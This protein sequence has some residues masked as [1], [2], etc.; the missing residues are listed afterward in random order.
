[1]LGRTANLSPLINQDLGVVVEDSGAVEVTWATHTTLAGSVVTLP[2]V[3]HPSPI[4]DAHQTLMLKAG[5][6]DGTH[7]ERRIHMQ[8]EE[9]LLLGMQIRELL[10]LM[11]MVV[12][13]RHTMLVQGHRI[14]ITVGVVLLLGEAR[15]PEGM[16]LLL[17]AP[18]GVVL[19]PERQ[20]PGGVRVRGGRRQGML[21][22]ER[23]NRHLG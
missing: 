14:L 16:L 21:V 12:K 7:Q 15:L 22:G 23:Q 17:E 5:H 4:R 2:V 13:H 8:M 18:H 10:I 19:H 20:M 3:A 9:K 6:Q 1:M 11:L